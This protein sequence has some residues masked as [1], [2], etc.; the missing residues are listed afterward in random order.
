MSELRESEHLELKERWTDRALEDLAAFANTNG[1]KLLIGVRDDSTVIGTKADDCELQRL[2]NLITS[3]L[4]ITPSLSVIDLEGHKVIEIEVN[5]ARG[6][7]PCKG[8]Y[9]R[10]VGSTNRDF[11]PQ[12]LAR[13]ALKLSG[14]SWDGL[15][16]PWH[17][18]QVE[19]QAIANFVRAAKGRLP[20]ADPDQP[21][22]LLRN[23]GLLQGECLTNGGVL[24]FA[25]QPQ[26]L[27]PTA[28]VR[29]GVFRGP[30]EIVD[31]HDLAGTLFDQLDAAMERFR[32]LL[33]VRFDVNVEQPTL[34]GLQRKDVW[35]YPLE[36]LR[37]A[38][39][40]ALIHR[41]YTITADIQIR[42]Y[43]D[44]LSV[45]NPGGLPKGIRLEQLKEP[46][47]PSILRNP[48][49]AQAFYFAGLIERWGTGTTHIV[50]LCRDQ[51]LPE[52]EFA[53]QAG[54]FRLIFHKDP[55]TPDQLRKLGL[56]ERQ[57]Q[58]VLYVKQHGS[59][60]NKEYQELT[61]V[62][63]RMATLDLGDLAKKGVLVRTGVTGRG[64]R[65][66]ATK[67]QKAQESRNN[68]AEGA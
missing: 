40:N 58:A 52:P 20:H 7:I 34:E 50:R 66:A 57:I 60:G 27:F 56:N 22:R 29:I 19:P 18:D 23:L 10:R 5:P 42:L 53:E 48:L 1:G 14:E 9:L 16:S 49:L 68:A 28:Q 6:L 30:T 38:V 44:H 15:P 51:D 54:N 13:H 55:Y 64:T 46:E 31:S 63:E 21:E 17:F 3:R 33:K 25:R 39:I 26:R 35:E 32:R 41:D 11:T 61:G 47:H 2:A 62:K 65:Y 43:D 12:E 36:A 45:W 67:A 59:I 24:L 8:R 4:G 37:E